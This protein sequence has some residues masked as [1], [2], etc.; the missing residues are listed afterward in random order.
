MKEKQKRVI[1][2]GAGPGGLSAAMML[3]SKGYNVDVYEKQDRVGGRNAAINLG[4]FTFDAGPTFLMMKDVLERIYQFC[5]KDLHDY[6]KI[7]RL[8]PMYRLVFKDGKSFYPSPDEDKMREQLER[9]VPGSFYGYKR[10]KEKERKKYAKLIPCLEVPY[11]KP[12]DFFTKRLI[13]ALPYLDAHVSFFNVLGRY[14]KN[15]DVKIAF[16]FQ[17]KYI[18]MSP[19]DAPGTFSIISYIEHGGGIYHVEGGLHKL[20]QAMAKSATEDGAQIHLNTPVKRIIVEKGV[21]RGVEFADGQREM[22]DYVVVNA[23][24][25]AAMNTLVEPSQRGRW[26]EKKLDK[27]LLSCSTFMLYLGL[28]RLYDQ[29]HHNIIF[30]DDYKANVFDITKTMRLSEDFSFYVQN[31]SI[32]DKTLA[33]KGKS[34][35]YVLVPVPNMRADIDWEEQKMKTRDAVLDAMEKRGGFQGIRDAIEEEKIITPADWQNNHD[36]YKGAVFNLGHNVSQML[37]FR[38][39]NEFENFKNCYLVGGGTHPGSGLPTIYESGRISAQ[40][41]MKRDGVL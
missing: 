8:D 29:P 13:T 41:I 3:A 30:A 33:P 28:N 21:A 2:I 36:V 10:Y 15:D 1:V 34:T 27:K 25:G 5:G 16:T 6:N 9:F 17:A 37:Y 38:P 20:S 22:A 7:T 40:L 24:F 4:K 39:H 23:D 32:S 14:F 12:S 11:G 19:W 35:L 26:S 18:G 31:A